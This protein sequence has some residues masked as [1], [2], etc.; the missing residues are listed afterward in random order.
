MPPKKSSSREI[1][2]STFLKPSQ[3]WKIRMKRFC[4]CDPKPKTPGNA[5]SQNFSPLPGPQLSPVTFPYPITVTQLT[6]RYN[7]N[8]AFQLSHSKWLVSKEYRPFL[9]QRNDFVFFFSLRSI[10]WLGGGFKDLFI[11]T[12]QP[13]EMI[14]FDELYFSNRLET[15]N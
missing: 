11:F 4:W 2:R 9:L 1:R 15:T 3:E 14:R 7:C 10:P 8:P 13:G 12:P 5:F 6:F